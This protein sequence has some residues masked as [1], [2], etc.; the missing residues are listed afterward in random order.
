MKKKEAKE[1]ARNLIQD[2]IA[3]AYYILFE[4]IDFNEYSKE[5]KELINEQLTKEATKIERIKR[6]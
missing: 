6:W 1:I 2:A 4:G 5:E 3:R